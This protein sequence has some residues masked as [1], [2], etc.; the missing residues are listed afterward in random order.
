M[1]KLAEIP[2]DLS[3]YFP[4][5]GILI[6]EA[7]KIHNHNPELRC[8]N[9]DVCLEVVSLDGTE[10]LPQCPRLDHVVHE[11]NRQLLAQ[12]NHLNR[13]PEQAKN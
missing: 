6:Q 4:L 11:L 5:F 12:L 2:N 9:L 13:G 8:T 7:K 3:H 1:K 10:D